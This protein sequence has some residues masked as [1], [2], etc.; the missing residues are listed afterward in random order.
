MRSLAV[1]SL[2]LLALVLAVS[3]AVS[4]QAPPSSGDCAPLLAPRHGSMQQ[5]N[6]TK[7]GEPTIVRFRCALGRVLEGSYSARCLRSGRWSHPVP[8]CRSIGLRAYPDRAG[9]SNIAV[10]RLDSEGMIRAITESAQRRHAAVGFTIQSGAESRVWLLKASNASLV[11]SAAHDTYLFTN[12]GVLKRFAG[13]KTVEAAQMTAV[14]FAQNPEILSGLAAETKALHKTN[15]DVVGFSVA[16]GKVFQASVLGWTSLPLRSSAKHHAFIL[17]AEVEDKISERSCALAGKNSGRAPLKSVAALPKGTTIKS[18]RLV[19]AA[20]ARAKNHR[21]LAVS[22]SNCY[23]GNSA[24]DRFGSTP[25]ASTTEAAKSSCAI[26]SKRAWGLNPR[27]ASGVVGAGAVKGFFHTFELDRSILPVPDLFNGGFETPD[28]LSP[29]FRGATPEGQQSLKL[30]AGSDSLAD[31]TV[32]PAGGEVGIATWGS[33][34]LRNHTVPEGTNVLYMQSSGR[35]SQKLIGLKVGKRYRV[36]FRESYRLDQAPGVTLRVTIGDAHVIYQ[37]SYISV[38]L[39]MKRTVNFKAL[40]PEMTLTFSASD[41]EAQRS[42]SGLRPLAT[43]L[44]DDVSVSRRTGIARTRVGFAGIANHGRIATFDASAPELLAA[45][46]AVSRLAAKEGNGALGFRVS[47]NVVSS[48]SEKDLQSLKAQKGSRI[49]LANGT[50]LADTT[51]ATHSGHMNMN[52][53]LV[54]RAARKLAQHVAN[55]VGM[56]LVSDARKGVQ[57]IVLGEDALPLVKDGAYTTY[58]FEDGVVDLGCWAQPLGVGNVLSTLQPMHKG[59]V[60]KQACA[61]AAAAAGHSF[62][63]L[64]GGNQCVSG[65]SNPNNPT[66]DLYYS[67]G[68]STGC[69]TRCVG[70]RSDNCGGKGAASVFRLPLYSRVS[71]NGHASVRPMRLSSEARDLAQQVFDKPGSA[72]FISANPEDRLA[73]AAAD[74]ATA[75]KVEAWSHPLQYHFA[76]QQSYAVT[77][78]IIQAPSLTSDHDLTPSAWTFEGSMDGLDWVVLDRQSHVA[79]YTGQRRSFSLRHRQSFHFHRLLV[80]ENG[81]AGVAGFAIQGLQLL[82]RR[83]RVRFLKGLYRFEDPTRPGLDSS[84]EENDLTVFGPAAGT[85][86]SNTL[87]VIQPSKEAR[88]HGKGVLQLWSKVGAPASYMALDANLTLPKGFPQGGRSFGVAFWFQVDSK[89]D[90]QG[91]W[92]NTSQPDAAGLGVLGWGDLDSEKRGVRANRISLDRDF[93]AVRNSFVGARSPAA[94]ARGLATPAGAP[95]VD[96]WH[97]F[98]TSYDQ[99]SGS[100]RLWLDGKLV[101]SRLYQNPSFAVTPRQFVLGLTTPR[102]ATTDAFAGLLDDVAIFNGP[103]TTPA[104][105]QIAAGGFK[106]YLPLSCQGMSDEF[107]I[108]SGVTWGRATTLVKERYLRMKCFTK[109][110]D[111]QVISDQY[112]TSPVDAGRAGYYKQKQYKRQHCATWPSVLTKKNTWASCPDASSTVM[113]D[114]YTQEYA[115]RL[116]H[117]LGPSRCQALIWGGEQGDAQSGTKPF[118]FTACA[119]YL[120]DLRYAPGMRIVTRVS[121]FMLTPHAKIHC[122]SNDLPT[123]MRVPSSIHA[124]WICD[125]TPGCVA[126]TWSGEKGESESH[127]STLVAKPQPH[128][129]VLCSSIRKS[130]IASFPG[131]GYEVGIKLN[132]YIAMSDRF[133]ECSPYS[134]LAIVNGTTSSLAARRECDRLDGFG[135]TARCMSYSWDRKASSTKL[136]ASVPQSAVVFTPHVETGVATPKDCQEMSDSW[137]MV[138]GSSWGSAPF[139]IKQAFQTARCETKPRTCQQLSEAYGLSPEVTAEVAAATPGTIRDS[140]LRQGCRSRPLVKQS[141]FLIAASFDDLQTQVDRLAAKVAKLDQ[142]L[143]QPNPALTPK[144]QSLLHDELRAVKSKLQLKLDSLRQKQTEELEPLVARPANDQDTLDQTKIIHEIAAGLMANSFHPPKRT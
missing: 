42:A 30:K 129:L 9:L 68:R 67:G 106:A 115:V 139:E 107:A 54:V 26:A 2:L 143:E 59:P 40:A 5:T 51:T 1:C 18:A 47:D 24:P 52:H 135:G 108:E 78:Y 122:D 128:K 137:A 117:L 98:A 10:L 110:T 33:A 112:A 12:A 119:V 22:E 109:P 138:Y 14:S 66:D 111:C 61:Q 121:K 88:K 133:A 3:V 4:A 94:G 100:Q 73:A 25:L 101:A 63:A 36:Q 53:R 72:T 16:R 79:F 6:S 17:R 85:D 104:V 124:R 58:L 99:V 71:K 7:P 65:R 35:I 15:N 136:C 32:D 125:A 28:V 97:H 127:A 93:T 19:C 44:L 89:R 38:P 120:S 140:W 27:P 34:Q 102:A 31:W 131:S 13:M 37:N 141:K 60:T 77:R 57:V 56:T 105:T 84:V 87:A 116:C 130:Q 82:A 81:G 76:G 92:G 46:D 114:V 21:F 75:P 80:T 95:L 144:E 90:V 48:L 83:D 69:N 91:R 96:A 8:V 134:A 123:H 55:A 11:P 39:W 64:Q 29:V 142:R 118:Q 86:R 45:F 126:Y 49:L 70:D 132:S 23:S 103:L 62:F 50:T 113:Q 74:P 43:V 41:S 20:I